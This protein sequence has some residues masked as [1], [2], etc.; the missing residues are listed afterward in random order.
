MSWL[1]PRAPVARFRAG[2][3]P[4]E[5]ASELLKKEVIAVTGNSLT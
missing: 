1:I 5:K 2:E 3:I 4:T